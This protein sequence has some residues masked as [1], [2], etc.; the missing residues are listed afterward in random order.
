MAWT[1]LA[2]RH[3]PAWHHT[4]W[5]HPAWHP[6]AADMEGSQAVAVSST[7]PVVGQ[8]V[9]VDE[10]VG[11]VVLTDNILKGHILQSSPAEPSWSG[12][13]VV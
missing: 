2:W 11:D 5:H 7:E 6:L 9:H 1:V 8:Q 12:G 3:H 10:G 4:A 13:Q